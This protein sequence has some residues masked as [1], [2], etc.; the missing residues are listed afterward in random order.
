MIVPQ[1]DD[2]NTLCILV[3]AE[4]VLPT[5]ITSGGSPRR[6]RR[7]RTRSGRRC[8]RRC[9]ET[10]FQAIELDVRHHSAPALGVADALGI[11]NVETR[12]WPAP[13]RLLGQTIAIHA[14]K[15]VVRQ[16]GAA[17]ERE[18][19]A[20]LGEDWRSTMPTGA[21]VATAT[22]AAVARVA[23]VD[24]TTGHAVHDGRTEVGRA[25]G[26]GRT[27]IDPWGDFSS[28]RWL[29]FLDDVKALSKPIPA[30]GHQS[31]WR[32]VGK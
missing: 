11:K 20:R 26:R 32:W 5:S 23:Y 21:V 16:P 2:G 15:R 9:S 14:G 28:G 4:L 27:P 25:P 18:L 31:F 17:I 22:L 13:E 6:H 10:I 8:L 24:P 19:R 12:S 3:I 7:G 30:V 1:R 29:W